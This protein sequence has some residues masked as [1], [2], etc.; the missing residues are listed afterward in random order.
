MKEKIMEKEKNIRF[1]KHNSQAIKG[2]AIMMMLLHHMYLSRE[3]F[4]GYK[5]SFAPFA[6]GTIIY[7]SSFFKICVPIYVFISGYGLYLSYK[8]S[9]STPCRWTAKRLIKTMSG[10]WIIWLLAAVI[11]QVMFGYVSKVYFTS[12][13]SIRNLASMGID[14]LGL[15]KLFGTATMNGTWWYMSAAIIFIIC[16]PLFMKNEDSLILILCMVAAIPH[17]LELEVMGKS[18][19]YAFLPAFLMGMCVAKYDLYDRWFQIWNK[20]IKR[21][22]KFLVELIVLYILYKAYGKLPGSVYNEIRWGLIPVVLIAF[23]CE[24]IIVIPGIR[25]ILLFL[26]KHS[27]NIFLIHTFIR[28][29]FWKDYA[30][31]SGHFLINILAVILPSIVISIVLEWLKK[32]TGY[33]RLVQNICTKI[34]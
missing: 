6:D 17:M 1:D 32:V 11:F 33:N 21:I 22:V 34:G 8:K 23:C 3:R 30:Y 4:E 31:S 19:I 25:Q 9:N 18:E 20:S 14:F 29:Y 28:Q 24:F 12:E 26:G 7:L 2:I 13:S 27:M 16:V 5:V 10:F 15:A